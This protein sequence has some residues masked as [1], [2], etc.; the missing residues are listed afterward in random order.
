MADTKIITLLIGGTP[1]VLR[2]TLRGM[3]VVARM[4]KASKI[5]NMKNLLENV[6]F[7]NYAGIT[8]AL[9]EAQGV[10]ASITEVEDSVDDNPR[11]PLDLAEYIGQIFIGE[12]DDTADKVLGGN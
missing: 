6:G 4:L 12:E 2:P 1:H 8:Q 11:F 9:L 7:D 10:K 5:A 3:R